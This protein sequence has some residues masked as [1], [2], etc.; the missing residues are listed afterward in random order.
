MAALNADVQVMEHFPAPL[1]AAE[2]DTLIEGIEESFDTRGFGLWALELRGEAPLIGM[3]GLWQLDPVLPFAPGVELGW[4]LARP[5]WGRGL[6]LEGARASAAYGFGELGL[7]ELLA[8]TAAGNKRSRA[9]MESL[10][11]TRDPIEDFMHPKLARGHRLAA[12]VL[13]RLAPGSAAPGGTR[14]AVSSTASTAPSRS[15]DARSS[16]PARAAAPR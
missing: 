16:A 1:T 12:H 4:R 2:S 7:P 13:Y 8:Y 14:A 10:G 9:L 11:M 5:Y 15:T 6:A 3:V